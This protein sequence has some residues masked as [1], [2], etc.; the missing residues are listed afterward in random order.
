MP[1]NTVPKSLSWM[2]WANI[3]ISLGQRGAVVVPLTSALD[4]GHSIEGF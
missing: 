3:T 1:T 2:R 4:F